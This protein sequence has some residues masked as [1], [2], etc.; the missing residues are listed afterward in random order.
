V[1]AVD[2][3][4]APKRSPEDD[5][6]VIRLE[7]GQCLQTIG[8]ALGDD[9]ELA[10]FGAAHEALGRPSVKQVHQVAVPVFNPEAIELLEVL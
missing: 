2:V 7:G 10:A 5:E 9:F 1:P 4:E 8:D 3:P 6:G